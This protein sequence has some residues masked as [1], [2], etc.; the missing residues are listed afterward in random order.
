MFATGYFFQDIHESYD[1]RALS[2]V[3]LHPSGKR[4]QI[5]IEIDLYS[6]SSLIYHD[7]PIKK[8]RFSSY[9]P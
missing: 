7:L 9:L 2:I 6:F 1:D 4:L 3:I 8:W 5:P